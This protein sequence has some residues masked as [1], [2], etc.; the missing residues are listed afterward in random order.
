[1]TPVKLDVSGFQGKS[2]VI[3]PD[4]AD[5]GSIKNKC[6]TCGSGFFAGGESEAEK[7]K[8]M[9]ETQKPTA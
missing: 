4:G 6:A 3:G 8:L 9:K 5:G 7:Q 2:T 1:M